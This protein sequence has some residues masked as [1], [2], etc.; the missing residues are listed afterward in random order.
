MT[1]SSYLPPIPRPPHDP[2][3]WLLDARAGWKAAGGLAGVEV[4]PGDGALALAMLP[5]AGRLLSEASGSFGG[6]RPPG[7][8][9]F[10]P[11]GT[12]YLLDLARGVLRRFDPCACG[13]VTEPCF[14]GLGDGPAQFR[15]PHGIAICRGRL[16]VCDTGHHRLAVFDLARRAWRADWVPPASAMPDQPWTP[17]AIGFDG[18]GRAFVTDAANGRVHRFGPSGRWEAA[19]AGLGALSWLAVDCADR[20]RLIVEGEPGVITI[21]ADGHR[22][23][24][25][26]TLPTRPEALAPVFPQPRFP[27]DASGNM[28]LS[29][30]LPDE[31]PPSS[32]L[33]SPDG[34]PIAAPAATTGPIY[35]VPAGGGPGGSFTSSALDSRLYRC[36]WHRVVLEA[37]VPRGT[38]LVVATY[39]S[40]VPLG[41]DEVVALPDTAWQTNLD[42]G[43]LDGPW[44]GLIRC[45]GGRFL[46]LRLRFSSNGGATPAVRSMVVEY[47]RISLRRYLPAVFG[48]E[49]ASADFTDRFL[50][51]FDTVFRQ[52]ERTIDTQAKF[53]DPMA[54]PAVRD[55]KS[56][57]DFLTWLAG[58]VGQTP[59]RQWPERLRRLF[60]KNAG[61][62]AD[63]RGTPEGL[64][65]QL[66][67]FLGMN[68]EA[69]R[70]N[71]LVD[72]CCPPKP[73][74]CAPAP[75]RPKRPLPPL[76]LEHFRLRRWLS[77]GAGRLG[78]DAMLWGQS[79]VDRSPLG[80][81]AQVGVTR[82]LT[83]QDPYRDPFHVFAH[84]FTVFLPARC[85]RTDA[86]RKAVDNLIRAESP[87]HTAY[88]IRYVEPFFR[89]GVQSTIGFDAVV[90]RA[91]QGVTLGTTGLDGTHA[92][93]APPGAP[94]TSALEVGR[95][96]R[97]GRAT[98]T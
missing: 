60:L 64:R 38:R 34:D 97:I 61:A 90:G 57:V 87:A 42:V 98:L 59:S 12:L 49:P 32:S 56:G 14:G 44:D 46:W 78:E 11:G 66:Y 67:L 70:P 58:W 7:N 79:I 25:P 65:R 74:N 33:F 43:R 68:A 73:L 16:F 19:F 31:C 86:D 91:P 24:L 92:L 41:D 13:F 29:A 52:I 17:W 75:H 40:E 4:R 51:L 81:G 71:G 22:L 95:S 27:V 72:A 50:A 47:P 39:T 55:P 82:L 9:A 20:L 84:R 76:I 23:D 18:R 54:T 85:G 8:A 62:L 35:P 10:G 45:D 53:F 15:D 83:E 94:A 5:G 89:V 36:Q 88:Q 48:A 6:L 30:E 80:D 26:G 1:L 21:D 2:S 96:G 28:D 77:V 37:T 63:L 3:W 69:R 93:T